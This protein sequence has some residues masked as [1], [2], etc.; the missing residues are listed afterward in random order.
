MQAVGRF[1]P[2]L[3]ERCLGGPTYCDAVLVCISCSLRWQLLALIPLLLPQHRHHAWMAFTYNSQCSDGSRQ[4]QASVPI[5]VE[6]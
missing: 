5:E 2:R 4:R 1:Q 6:R 3:I